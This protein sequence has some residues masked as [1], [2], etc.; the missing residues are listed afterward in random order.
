[1]ANEESVLR[2]ADH[3]G[4]RLLRVV[5]RNSARVDD[6]VAR[7]VNTARGYDVA[8]VI[9]PNLDHIG[10]DPAPIC[11]VCDVVTVEPDQTYAQAHVSASAAQ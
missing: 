11:Q 4:Y 1:M 5:V 6:P 10:G 7:L 2:R 9:T 8:A 3:M